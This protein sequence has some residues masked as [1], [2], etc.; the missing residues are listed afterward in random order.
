MTLARLCHFLLFAA[1]GAVG[2]VAHYAVLI[3]LVSGAGFGPVVGATAG[4][5]TGALVNYLLS[6]AVVFRGSSSPHHEAAAKFL[7]V[8]GVGL[9]LN[10]ALM[11]LL[12]SFGVPYILAQ[13][14][15]TALLVVWHY[16]G[17]LLWTFR[18][19]SPAAPAAH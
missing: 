18:T 13:I 5:L 6:R 14:G 8:A 1:L 11:A 15:I 4:F 16:A 3:G 9:V 17:N 7:L 10:A 19:D 12:T 2:T